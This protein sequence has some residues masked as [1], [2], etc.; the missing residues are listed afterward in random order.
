MSAG[1]DRP[2]EPQAA[3]PQIPPGLAGILSFVVPGLGHLLLRMWSRAAIWLAGW[4]LV[5]AASQAS[6]SVPMLLLMFIAGLDAYFCA[7]ARGQSDPREAE[8]RSTRYDRTCSRL[9]GGGTRT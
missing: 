3:W 7:R 9:G 1:G 6:H 8:T 4:I 5:G 2:S